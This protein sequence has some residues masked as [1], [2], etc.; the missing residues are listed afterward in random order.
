[1]SLWTKINRSI[2]F[3]RKSL[4][5]DYIIVC[6][7]KGQF[8]EKTFNQLTMLEINGGSVGKCNDA[9]QTDNHHAHE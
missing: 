5:E 6:K 4:Q 7:L 9:N 8:I 3:T 1:M 2:Q